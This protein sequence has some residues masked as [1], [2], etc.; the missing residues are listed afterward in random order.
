MATTFYEDLLELDFVPPRHL[1]K[2]D[3]RTPYLAIK[4]CKST[5][6]HKMKP[7]KEKRDRTKTIESKEKTKNRRYDRDSHIMMMELM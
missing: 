1:T 2:A 5:K 3:I 7:R 6:L 4:S